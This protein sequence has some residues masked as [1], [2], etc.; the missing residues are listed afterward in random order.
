MHLAAQSVNG[1][2]FKLCFKI[3]TAFLPRCSFQMEWA[4]TGRNEA[5]IFKGRIC[6]V[7]G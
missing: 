5:I 7:G 6:R 2:R 1:A 3:R 4:P